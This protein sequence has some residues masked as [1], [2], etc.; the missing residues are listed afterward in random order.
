MERILVSVHVE[1]VDREVIRRQVERFEDLTQRKMF[2]VSENNDLL[3]VRV[4][5]SGRQSCVHG[6]DATYIWAP[7]HLALDES[8]HVLLVHACRMVDMSVDLGDKEG[9]L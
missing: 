1:R 9:R 6:S 2:A 7:L 5:A 3:N 4:G 8:Q